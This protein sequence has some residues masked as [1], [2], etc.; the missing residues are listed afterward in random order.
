MMLIFT[1]C[2]GFLCLFSI[3]AF[4]VIVYILLFEDDFMIFDYA[5]LCV[6]MRLCS[7]PQHTS[8]WIKALHR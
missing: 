2:L 4:E 1:S 3:F 7:K 5:H 6:E 8:F